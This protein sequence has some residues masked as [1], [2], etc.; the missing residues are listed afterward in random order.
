M[1][2]ALVVEKGF[3][4][5]VEIHDVA[6][7]RPGEFPDVTQPEPVVGGFHLVAVLDA[8]EEDSVVVADAV[9]HRGNFKGREG[10]HETGCQSSQAAVPEAGVPLLF[11]QF[12]QGM[13][14]LGHGFVGFLV[15]SEVDQAV[16]QS[17]PDQ[18][19]QG[20]VIDPFGVLLVVGLLGGDPSLYQ[21]V[22][23]S[24]GD[25]AV[26]VLGGRGILV[27]PERILHMVQ[28]RLFQRFRIH[29]EVFFDKIRRVYER[30]FLGCHG[31]SSIVYLNSIPIIV[32][33]QRPGAYHSISTTLQIR[34]TR[35]ILSWVF[36][37]SRYC[38]G[39]VKVKGSTS[40]M[41]PEGMLT[42]SRRKVLCL[43]GSISIL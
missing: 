43:A 23:G 37:I 40:L 31:S 33:T 38:P 25:A 19:F 28:E 3:H 8:L 12:L 26:A 21:P 14:K 35:C 32:H 39:S 10:I 24:Q 18:E 22:P 9:A 30:A 16:A 2:L 5:S 27:F 42:R 4:L 13:A 20:E 41:P 6:E 17:P 15:H 7:F 34:S 36:R 1:R 29:T 11:A